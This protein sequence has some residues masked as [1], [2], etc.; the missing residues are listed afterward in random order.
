MPSLPHRSPVFYIRHPADGL[1]AP[2]DISVPSWQNLPGPAGALLIIG[3]D[4]SLAIPLSAGSLTGQETQNCRRSFPA[5]TPRP[6]GRSP[7]N[8]VRPLPG[9]TSEC[10]S[11]ARAGDSE[12]STGLPG[13]K[14]PP[15]RVLSL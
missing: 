14:S 11:L 10:R 2:R 1:P 4:L 3:S 9:H 7:Y 13:K 12:L 6:C 15:L 5:E 8:R